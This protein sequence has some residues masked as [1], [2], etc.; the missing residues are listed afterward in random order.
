ML[1]AGS[2]MTANSSNRSWVLL[3]C[4]SESSLRLR[5]SW[6][7]NP[8]ILSGTRRRVGEATEWVPWWPKTNHFAL[9]DFESDPASSSSC[10][11]TI[12]DPYWP[13]AVKMAAALAAARGSG[14]N[15][16]YRDTNV[17]LDYVWTCFAESLGGSDPRMLDAESLCLVSLLR[18]HDWKR[19]C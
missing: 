4:K 10:A 15:H 2:M 11:R 6:E 9:S 18:S 1:S 17:R 5:T 7:E 13:R 3:H 14:R 19:H 16:Q 8:E 12:E